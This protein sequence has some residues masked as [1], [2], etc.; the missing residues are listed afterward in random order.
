M[1]FQFDILINVIPGAGTS[2]FIRFATWSNSSV[3]LRK[4][5]CRR[6]THLFGRSDCLAMAWF[7]ANGAVTITAQYAL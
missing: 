1:V 2:S 5:I 3:S 7:N 4:E 6:L